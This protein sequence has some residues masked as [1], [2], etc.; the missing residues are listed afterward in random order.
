MREASLPLRRST[1]ASLS[2][3]R[4]TIACAI[5]ATFSPSR[6]C[7]SLDR[8]IYEAELAFRRTNSHQSGL[9]KNKSTAE[10]CR[11]P[12][13]RGLY[14]RHSHRSSKPISGASTKEGWLF[15]SRNLSNHNTKRC[16]LES[17]PLRQGQKFELRA[18]CLNLALTKG[19]AEARQKRSEANRG[20]VSEV[21]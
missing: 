5:R 21:K 6:T 20:M 18:L 15:A 14:G 17:I 3:V 19:S 10:N 8:C 16:H 9:P 1:S 7:L 4:W 11:R 13:R 12:V 2:W